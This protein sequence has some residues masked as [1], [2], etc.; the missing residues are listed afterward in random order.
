MWRDGAVAHADLSRF[1]NALDQA[2]V[3]LG[4]VAGNR[5]AAA[6]DDTPSIVGAGRDR[7]DRRG[8]GRAGG[9]LRVGRVMAGARI[10]TWIRRLRSAD[11]FAREAES[12]LSWCRGGRGRRRSRGSERPG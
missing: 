9:A 5:E 6:S 8:R 4:D 12:V 11:V 1:A 2:G 7:G 3:G 10:A